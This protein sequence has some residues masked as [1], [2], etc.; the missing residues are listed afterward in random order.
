MPGSGC[1]PPLWHSTYSKLRFFTKLRRFICAKDVVD[2]RSGGEV[3]SVDDSVTVGSVSSPLAVDEGR[4]DLG[5]GDMQ[6]S[7]KMLNFGSWEEKERAAEEIRRLAEV[8]GVKIRKVL[9][10]LGVVPSLVAMVGSELSG[11]RRVAVRALTEL[12]NGTFTNKVI[13]VESGVL[14]KV[15]KSSENVDELLR[16]DFAQLLLSLSSLANTQYSLDSLDFIPFTVSILESDSDLQT[17]NTC[18]GSLHN[19]SATLD[20]AGALITNGIVSLLLSLSC[21]KETSDNALTTL[22]NLV[23]TIAGRKDIESSPLVPEALIEVLT[24]ED[25]PKSQESAAYILMILAHQS[26]ESHEKMGKS[27]IVPVLLE[28]ALLGSPLA[29]KRALKMLQ[30][31][32][33]ERQAKMGPHSGPHTARSL[34]LGSP[35]NQMGTEEGKRLMKK[36]VTESL[37]KN[38]EIITRR[39]NA[40]DD[41]SKRMSFVS[42]SSKSLPF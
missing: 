10:E 7:V 12:A 19:L 25:K 32:K 21:E 29:Q 1:G 41:S 36:M 27:G 26:F 34:T 4:R 39:A 23:V 38:M 35:V 30:W 15:P 17:K 3:C 33:D 9:A 16:Q 22:G 18:L 31:F 8:G 42:S 14:S 13:I 6:R 40:A 20:S 37:Y 2:K 11:R 28:V 5:L 24:W